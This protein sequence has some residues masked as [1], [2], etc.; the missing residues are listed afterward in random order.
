MTI[1]EEEQTIYEIH[2]HI[3]CLATKEQIDEVKR[4][5]KLRE[6]DLTREL[7]SSLSSGD[8]VLIKSK[9]K[10]ERGVIIKI[11]RT[12]ALVDIESKGRPYYTV[13]F[14]MIRKEQ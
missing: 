2:R 14:S 3:M 13:P 4:S 5:I 8:D 7:I 9:N 12:R 10:T 1:V 6:D 11:N